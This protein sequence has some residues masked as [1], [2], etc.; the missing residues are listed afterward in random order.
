MYK[1]KIY[2]KCIVIIFILVLWELCR[3]VEIVAVHDE[4]TL[5]V[6]HFPLMKFRRISWWEKN[7]DEIK[8][9]FGVP[10]VESDGDYDV[11]IQNFGSGY[12]IDPGRT[13]GSEFVCFEDIKF[14][15]NCIDKEPLLNIGSARNEKLYYR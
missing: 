2:Q 9:K 14:N 6:K 3:P 4:N 5:L 15:A 1:I 8:T 7:K 11:F 13:D 12:K 10:V